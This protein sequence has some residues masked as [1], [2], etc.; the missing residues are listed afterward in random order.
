MTVSDKLAKLRSNMKEQGVEAFVVPSGDSH[1]SEYTANYWKSLKWISGF[2]GSAGTVVI[3]MKTS[4]LWTDS[5]YF[6]QAENQLS[7]TEILLM[8]MKV[9]GTPSIEE[10]LKKQISPNG[11]VAVDGKLFSIS[12]FNGLQTRLAPLKLISITDPFVSIWEDR[13]LLPHSRAFLLS[14]SVTGMS[15]ESKMQVVREKLGFTNRS[16]YIVSALDEIAWLL[17]IRGSDI[18]CNPLVI[19]YAVL[20]KSEVLLFVDESKFETRDVL[21]LRQAGIN[22]HPYEDFDTFWKEVKDISVYYNPEKLSI[23]VYETLCKHNLT[24]VEESDKYGIISRLKARKN[25]V[26]LDGFRKA[27]IID[28][29]AKVRFWKWIEENIGKIEI[30]EWSAAEKLQEF[31]KLSSA[32]V[33]DSFP[34][35]SAYQA[36][37]AMPHYSV[38]KENCSKLDK[39]GFYLVDSG[40]QY[41]F[42]TTD[43]TRTVYLGDMPSAEEK[44]DYT[45]ILKGMIGLSKAIFPAG[46]RGSQLDILAR[47]YLWNQGKNFLHGTGHGVG[48]FLCVH[49]GPQSIRMEENPVSIEIGMVTSNEPAYYVEGKYG[50]RIEN[51]LACVAF[52]KQDNYYCFE[53]LT[54]CP[55]DTKAVDINL[56]SLE[57]KDWLNQYHKKVYNSLKEGMSKDEILY[58]ER[59]TKSI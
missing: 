44:E 45:L 43:I 26:E 33:G 49:E 17:N 29:Q 20:G 51:L 25:S 18:F 58:L 3:T 42:G 1:F 12:N 30:S 50:I 47:T 55:I 15:R 13:P 48:H 39:S 34:C 38:K 23:G 10:W 16:Y 31:R 24:T 4:A 19:S 6:I 14:E 59:K 28:G 22:I 2:S 32:Y 27:M 54:L 11:I 8:K 57:E 41:Q 21:E 9:S 7:G 52:E 40:A 37:G 56:L 5:R 53:T 36:N 35:I 46:T